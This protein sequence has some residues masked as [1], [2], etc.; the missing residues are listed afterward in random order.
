MLI[1]G[2]LTTL[3]SLNF[4]YTRNIYNINSLINGGIRGF[5]SSTNLVKKKFLFNFFKIIIYLFL[6]QWQRP[7]EEALHLPEMP[8]SEVHFLLKDEEEDKG[9]FPAEETCDI[10]LVI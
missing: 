5:D 9:G 3:F 4:L 2:T 1:A 6:E 10:L 7:P 8:L